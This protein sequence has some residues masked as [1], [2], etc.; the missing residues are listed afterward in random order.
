MNRHLLTFTLCLLPL[1]AQAQSN[2]TMWPIDHHT[3]TAGTAITELIP[4][5]DNYRANLIS[6]TYTPAATA[7]DLVLMKAIAKVNLTAASAASDTTLDLSLATF[8]GD[9]LA[10][11]DYVVLEHGDG[12]HGLYL[13]SGL[14]TLVLTVNAI[15]K[16]ANSG[17]EVW[18][19]GAPSDSTYHQTI[20][21]IASTRTTHYNGEAGLMATGYDIGT[22]S[23]DGYGDPLVIYSANGTNAGTVNHGAARYER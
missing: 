18:I 7:H 22:Y 9:T 13:A 17:A 20:K 2:R 21:S 5:K 6:L 3:E 11:G 15:S 14:A 10:S 8:G 16:A 1:V 4:P 19:M 23:R 12:T